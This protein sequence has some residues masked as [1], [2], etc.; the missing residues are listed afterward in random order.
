MSRK[1]VY[2]YFHAKTPDEL[3]QNARRV[4]REHYRRIREAAPKEKLLEFRLV[5]DGYHCASFW[6]RR[7]QRA[8][9]FQGSMSLLL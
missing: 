1:V 4:Y 3:R 8:Y 2:G 5:R 6:E 9:L 7:C